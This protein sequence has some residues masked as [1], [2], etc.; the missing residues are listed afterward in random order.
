[1]NLG[2]IKTSSA[3]I[4]TILN[5]VDGVLETAAIAMAPE[6][7]GPSFLVIYFV[8]DSDV[9]NDELKHRMQKS[10][11]SDLNPLFKISDIVSIGKL[12]RTA[13]NKVMR[14]ILRAQYSKRMTALET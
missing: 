13:S 2:G 4:E 14:R 5:K 10:I 6:G 11:K 12:P 9:S 8:K 1:M 3:E 7:G